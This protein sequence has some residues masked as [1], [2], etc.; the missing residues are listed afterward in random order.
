MKT[1]M[2]RLGIM[3]LL[4]GLGIFYGVN[5]TNKGVEQIYGE[6]PAVMQNNNISQDQLAPS[7]AGYV[8]PVIEAPPELKELA[9]TNPHALETRI[10]QRL[11]SGIASTLQS[12]ADGVVGI[13]LAFFDRL[14]R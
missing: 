11:A 8:E 5:L 7:R 2:V 1:F 4:F 3:I 14:L 10:V 6:N 12:I 13:I 9:S